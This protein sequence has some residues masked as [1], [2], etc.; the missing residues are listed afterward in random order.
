MRRLERR[1]ALALPDALLALAASFQDAENA[2]DVLD[3]L[4][5][6]LAERNVAC[7]LLVHLP[8]ESGLRLGRATPPRRPAVGGPAPRCW[9]QGEWWKTPRL[10]TSA[11]KRGM[12]SGSPA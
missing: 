2:D 1:K 3:R 12:V 6:G 8:D 5:S 9:G 4:T 7:A 10:R 11:S